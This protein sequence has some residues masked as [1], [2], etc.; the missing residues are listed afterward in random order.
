VPVTAE[1]VAGTRIFWGHG[2]QDPNIPHALARRGR[3][4]LQQ[5]DADLTARDYAIGHWIDPQELRDAVEWIEQGP[6]TD[7]STADGR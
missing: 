5:V 7:R 4:R 3:E 2:L 1:A 6:R